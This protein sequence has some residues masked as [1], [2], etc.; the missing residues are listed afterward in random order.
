MVEREADVAARQREPLHGVEARG[1][2]RARRAEE[3][4]SGGHLVE[5]ALDLDSA[6]GR[7][8]RGPLACLAA[9]VDLDSPAIRAANT[10]FE[11]QPRHACDRRQRFAAEAEAGDAVDRVLRQL[12]RGVTLEREAHLVRAHPAAVVAHFN[13]LES[14]RG[15][16]HGQ[17]SRA[18]IERV[19][20]KFFE[21]ARRTLDDLARSDAI[22]ELRGQPSY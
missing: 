9:M 21:R 8:R 2:F 12:G 20:H 16:A 3:F 4:P 15:K 18:G 7:E 6:S 5:E 13:E 19:F 17:L 22:D 1:I 14:A 10:A 11:R